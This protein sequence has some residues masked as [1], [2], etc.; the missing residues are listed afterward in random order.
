MDDVSVENISTAD[1]DSVR[2]NRE[3]DIMSGSIEKISTV[4]K[5]SVSENREEDII[6]VGS[7]EIDV[8][9]ECTDADYY[10]NLIDTERYRTIDDASSSSSDDVEIFSECPSVCGDSKCTA[11]LGFSGNELEYDNLEVL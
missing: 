11:F 8:D 7:D 6:S 4:Y 3:G 1:G 10:L 2:E 5:D 9:E